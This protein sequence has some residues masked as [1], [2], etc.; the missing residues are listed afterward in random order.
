MK[1]MRRR[2]LSTRR[3]DRWHAEQFAKMIEKMDAIKGGE[4]TLLDRSL[5]MFGSS[6]SEGN[7]HDPGNLP[8]LLAG[9]GS[10]SLSSGRHLAAEG[11]VP[12]C[13][14]YLAMLR[15]N[16]LDLESFGDSNAELAI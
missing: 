8:I 11:Q 10:G 15:R 4:G 2:L 12:L 7:R 13:N 1:T 6:L 9:Q 5:V 14:L 3:I 16:G